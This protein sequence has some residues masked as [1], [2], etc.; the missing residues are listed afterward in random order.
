MKEINIQN[1]QNKFNNF[2]KLEKIE[3]FRNEYRKFAH[4][5]FKES[6]S[7]YFTLLH[8]QNN[9]TEY[10]EVQL[11]P[12]HHQPD[13]NCTKHVVPI[14][15]LPDEC[16]TEIFKRTNI[17]EQAVILVTCDRFHTIM[18]KLLLANNK[19]IEYAAIRPS[20]GIL[21][22]CRLLKNIKT[23]GY[24]F[25]F[26]SDQSI[27]EISI[28]FNKSNRIL[29]TNGDFLK[30]YR[31]QFKEIA[32]RLE[33]LR[34]KCTNTKD[35][36]DNNFKNIRTLIL[37]PYS[38][39]GKYALPNSDH[40]RNFKNLT[41]ICLKNSDFITYTKLGQYFHVSE[42]F[43]KFV[44]NDITFGNFEEFRLNFLATNRSNKLTL[45]IVY[46][47]LQFK[48]NPEENIKMVIF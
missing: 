21:T 28:D 5:T 34:I 20:R 24:N 9:P 4:I 40:L 45:E 17:H 38:G 31:K 2:G 3:I 39:A 11:A 12:I 29:T 6:F 36:F 41:T 47:S 1:L 25:E 13:K 14:L 32:D 19:F 16:L 43:H 8:F 48:E 23:K 33:I 37:I 26:T 22:A 46:D 7:A 35:G 44:L 42:K 15:S 18:E 27:F 30:E 10:Y